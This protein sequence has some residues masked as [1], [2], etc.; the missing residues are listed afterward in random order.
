VFI[1]T[2]ETLLLRATREIIALLFS[3][4]FFILG[5]RAGEMKGAGVAQQHNESVCVE[6][7]ENNFHLSSSAR[8]RKRKR[9]ASTL[10]PTVEIAKERER[11]HP[12]LISAPC[13]VLQHPSSE[14]GAHLR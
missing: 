3:S 4:P 10:S 7:A 11:D 13:S 1:A 2:G 8:A 9:K 12:F 14:S 6:R 5:G